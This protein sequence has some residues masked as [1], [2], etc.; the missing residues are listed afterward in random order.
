MDR[1]IMIYI[2]L[3]IA[4]LVAFGFT[5]ISM[6]LARGIAKKI[7]AIDMPGEERRMHTA[8]TPR[9]GGL[10]LFFGFL[11]SVLCFCEITQELIGLL[12]GAVIIVMLG[13]IDDS[14]GLSAKLKLCVQ[15][16][17]ALTVIYISET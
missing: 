14:R 16:I 7:G 11:V 9:L 1:D 4:F 10:A 5:V 3:G 15:I 2:L 6:P 13:I 12:C 17:A 8:P